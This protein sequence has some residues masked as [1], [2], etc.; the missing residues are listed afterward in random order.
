[1]QFSGFRTCCFFY[2]PSQIKGLYDAPHFCGLP[3]RQSPSRQNQGKLNVYGKKETD[4][5]LYKNCRNE[6]GPPNVPLLAVFDMN[7]KSP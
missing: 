1:M 5:K 3:V 2:K 6:V 7:E 4:G